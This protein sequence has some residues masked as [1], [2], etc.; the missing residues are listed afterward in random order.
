MHPTLSR[1]IRATVVLAALVARPAIAQQATTTGSVRGVIRSSGQPL[2]DATVSATNT[3]TGTRRTSR[4]D[5]SGRYQLPFLDPG[6]YAVRAQHLGMRAVEQSA[7]HVSLGQVLTL[8]F[9]LESAPATLETQRISADV[10][11]LIEKQK[12][13]TDTRISEDQLR[14]LPTSDRNFKNLVVLT[15]GTSDVGATGAGGGQSIGGGRTA[16]SNILMDGANNNES[17]F[18]GDARG[19]DRLPF[20]YSIEAVKEIQVITAGYDVERGNFTGGTVNAVTKSG[21]NAFEGSFFDYVRGDRK[22]G[23]NLTGNDFLGRAPRN[24]SRQQYGASLGGPILKDR[25]HFFFTLDR[26]VGNEPKPVLQTGTTT[27]QIKAAGINA[28]TLAKFLNLAK[29]VYGYDLSQETGNL[30]QNIDETAV[31]GRLDYQ[32]SDRHSFTIRDNYL[33]F[34][35]SN[36]RLTISPSTNETTSNAGPYKEKANSLVAAL[37]SAF[38]NRFSNEARIQLA[39]DRKPRPSNPSLL[40]GPI[41]QIGVS[42]IVSPAGD[43]T[44]VTTAIFFGS[45]IVLHANNLEQNTTEFIDNVRYTRDAHTM[46]FGVNATRVHVFNNFFLNSLGSYTF[47]NLTDFANKNPARFT[48]ALPFTSTSGAPDALFAEYEYALYA[49]DEWQ[50]TPK[51]FVTYGLRYDNSR[52]PNAPAANTTLSGGPLALSTNF[53]PSGKGYVSPRGGFTYDPGADGQQVIRGGS[54]LF[55]GRAPYV[56]YGNVLSANGLTQLDLTCTGAAQIP[57]IDLSAY[58]KNASSIPSA[59][60]TGGAAV[61]SKASPVV[62]ARD[63]SQTRAWKSNLAYDRL[64]MKNWRMTVEGVYT[65]TSNDYTVRDANLKTTSQFTIEGGIPVYVPASTITAAGLTNINNSRVD[66]NFNNVFVQESKGQAN[67][68]QGIL[69]LRGTTR[70]GGLLASYTYDRTRD[71]GSVSCCIAGSDIFGATRANGNPNDLSNQEGPATY[72][73]PHSL[74]ISPTLNLPYGVALSGIFRRYSGL[75]WTPRY[76]GDVNGDGVT[77]DRLYIPTSAELQSYTFLNGATER[78]AFEAKIASTPCLNDHRGA[79]IGRGDCRNPWQSILDMRLGKTIST[80]RGQHAEISV[81]FFN[82]LNGLSKN[83]GK[84]FEVQSA[85]EQALQPRGF[86][87]ATQKFTYSYNTNFGLTEPSAF[88]LSQQFQVQLG[89][90]YAF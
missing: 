41:P 27:A 32:V 8:D 19:G 28:D 54:G 55:Y 39:Q 47:N 13:G 78:D 90:R 50:A 74:I 62:F 82:L 88:G 73:R 51:L 37:T 84:R 26:Q 81:D 45:D 17:Y 46:K 77:N 85:N 87:Q 35:Q 3:A 20:S 64:V 72:N 24:Y 10:A 68:M 33:N 44:N 53:Q 31:F 63:F 70:W 89:V 43:N 57:A 80:I 66:A 1:V 52:L 42:N 71:H 86:S 7:V 25:L 14:S 67:S 48:R 29:T 15:P 22:F 59:C 38:S 16:S 65:K 40:G 69:Q 4:T 76:R 30:Q 12:T 61:A 18:G 36:D 83:Q 75:P 56:L 9:T 34:V 49:Q 2:A 6:T 60:S 23:L 58:A 5:A 21:T 11:P 79:V